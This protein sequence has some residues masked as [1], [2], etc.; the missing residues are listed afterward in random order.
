[1]QGGY[2][3]QALHTLSRLPV[4][5]HSHIYFLSSRKVNAQINYKIIKTK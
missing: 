3:S 4:T 2:L 5:H 1:M